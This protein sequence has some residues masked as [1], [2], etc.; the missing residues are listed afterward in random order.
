MSRRRHRYFRARLLG[1]S[2]HVLCV[3][4]VAARGNSNNSQPTC[5]S[6]QFLLSLRTALGGA[7]M[8]HW[9]FRSQNT[10][11]TD[12]RRTRPFRYIGFLV[13]QL[14]SLHHFSHHRFIREFVD[15]ADLS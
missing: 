5:R 2:S 15:N 11:E 14:E 7:R 6:V 1:Y 3:T 12:S 4:R 8:R 10:P 9:H 13:A